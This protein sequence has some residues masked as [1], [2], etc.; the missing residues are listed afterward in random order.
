MGA[1]AAA[2]P[3]FASLRIFHDIAVQTI[4]AQTPPPAHRPFSSFC[5]AH[6]QLRLRAYIFLLCQRSFHPRSYSRAK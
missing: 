4:H 2:V 3:A 6:T 5:A 1:A